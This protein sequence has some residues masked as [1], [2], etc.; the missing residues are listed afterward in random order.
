[1]S[2][3][4]GIIVEE[5]PEVLYPITVI[6]STSNSY[7]LNI[8]QKL[9]GKMIIVGLAIYQV[10]SKKYEFFCEVGGQ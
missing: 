6:N 5:A 4:W 9:D 2:D 3:Q 10:T 1:M 8:Y 7:Q